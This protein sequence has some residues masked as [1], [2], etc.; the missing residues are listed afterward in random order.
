MGTLAADIWRPALVVTVKSVD[1]HPDET[2]PCHPE[3][4]LWAL[5]PINANF[6]EHTPRNGSI[7]MLQRIRPLTM[8][9]TQSDDGTP[10]TEVPFAGFRR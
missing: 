7:T 5:A 1:Q 2:T 9:R 6:S 3:E 10:S 8:G 4:R